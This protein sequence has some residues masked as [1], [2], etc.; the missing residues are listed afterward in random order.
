MLP[1]PLSSPPRASSNCECPRPQVPAG[2]SRGT[3]EAP[4]ARHL[5]GRSR[6]TEFPGPPPTCAPE[7]AARKAPPRGWRGA[8]ATRG[9]PF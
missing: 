2:I 6:R 5:R 4:V 7:R 9:G 8:R 1:G 3:G